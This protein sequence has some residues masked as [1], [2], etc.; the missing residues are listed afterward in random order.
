MFGKL[1]KA[2]L[3]YLGPLYLEHLALLLERRL[4]HLDFIVALLR[5]LACLLTTFHCILTLHVFFGRLTN[6][7]HRFEALERRAERL[8][9]LLP[10]AL[11]LREELAVTLL[12]A[13]FHTRFDGREAFWFVEVCLA[14]A[15]VVR[16]LAS[17]LRYLHYFFVGHRADTQLFI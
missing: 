1:I 6:R 2:I 12:G 9:K 3:K 16:N 10:M 5:E 7:L 17:H 15:I 8:A 14:L 13:G 4:A 11:E